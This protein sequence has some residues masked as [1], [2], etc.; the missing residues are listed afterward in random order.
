[1][2]LREG[3]GPENTQPLL[4]LCAGRWQPRKDSGARG[5]LPAGDSNILPLRKSRGCFLAFIP[6]TSGAAQSS[7]CGE[8]PRLCPPGDLSSRG[9]PWE[10]TRPCSREEK[11]V[12]FTAPP[13]PPLTLHLWE[14]PRDGRPPPP[15]P[16]PLGSRDAHESHVQGRPSRRLHP[17]TCV[18]G[19]IPSRGLLLSRQ[20]VGRALFRRDFVLEP[21]AW[22]GQ[23]PRDRAAHVE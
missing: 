7:R 5:V 8:A 2:K 19:V 16:C 17:D 15:A 12:M 1:M 10:R 11:R 6:E 21:S 22:L 4:C 13:W 18:G 23:R 3:N 20:L 9:S 14:L